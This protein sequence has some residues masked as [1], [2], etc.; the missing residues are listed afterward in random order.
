[1][2][3]FI[4]IAA[5]AVSTGLLQLACDAAEAPFPYGSPPTQ[6]TAGIHQ[7]YTNA[8]AYQGLA[9]NGGRGVP[10][11]SR[12]VYGDLNS[13]GVPSPTAYYGF[14]SLNSSSL[15]TGRYG[16]GAPPGYKSA[17][18]GVRRRG[19]GANGYGYGGSGYG[20]YGFGGFGYGASGY[21]GYRY[22]GYGAYGLYGYGA[23]GALGYGD[24]HSRF[25]FGASP[26]DDP[27]TYRFSGGSAVPHVPPFQNFAQPS[28]LA[29]YSY[30]YVNPRTPQAP[31]DP[32]TVENPFVHSKDSAASPDGK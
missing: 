9:S 20:G 32:E 31:A 6:G 17:S 23:T 25:Y 1:M 18:S 27:S 3:R 13:P 8:L 10:G 29:P 21:G 19:F 15:G 5:A 12:G 30:I 2:N 28:G 7:R 24:P 4:A 26:Y 22:G 14:G 16:N 11:A